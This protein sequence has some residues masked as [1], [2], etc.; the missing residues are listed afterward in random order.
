MQVQKIQYFF[1]ADHPKES[2]WVDSLRRIH[3]TSDSGNH[4]DFRQPY[5]HDLCESFRRQFQ[6]DSIKHLRGYSLEAENV[7]RLI[8]SRNH[9]EK[10]ESVESLLTQ[11]VDSKIEENNV[12]CDCDLQWMT[13]HTVSIF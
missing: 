5:R 8:I 2:N 4:R 3:F 12:E 9:I 11:A 13:A 7:G 1:S 10:L 6:Q